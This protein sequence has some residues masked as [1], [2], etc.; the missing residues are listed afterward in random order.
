MDW[1]TSD[2]AGQRSGYNETYGLLGSNKATDDTGQAFPRDCRRLAE[3]IQDRLKRRTGKQ[4]KSW[5]TETAH[6]DPWKIWELADPSY[7]RVIHP[8][9]KAHPTK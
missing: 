6:W 5:F 2:S 3:E 4:S 1:M 7:H 8:V 9:S